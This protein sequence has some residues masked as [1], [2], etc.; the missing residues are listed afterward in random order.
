MDRQQTRPPATSVHVCVTVCM[1]MCYFCACICICVHAC[2]C[3]VFTCTYCFESHS[4]QR[5]AAPPKPMRLA[6]STQMLW[7]CQNSS[8]QAVQA[9]TTLTQEDKSWLITPLTQCQQSRTAG[10][11][12][13]PQSHKASKYGCLIVVYPAAG[14]CCHPALLSNHPSVVPVVQCTPAGIVGH[15]SSEDTAL[16]SH[17][18]H[19]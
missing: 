11:D 10:T 4:F 18:S 17:V 8:R 6:H 15:G 1:R 13:R 14:P 12:A 19:E 3:D 16:L 5:S 9:P 7:A 2:V